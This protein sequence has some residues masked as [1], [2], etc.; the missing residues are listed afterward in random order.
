MTKIDDFSNERERLQ[1]IMQSY[2]GRD[3][4]RFLTIDHQVYQDG[5]LPKAS[6]ELLGLTASLVLRC[7]DCIN[8]H[9]IECHKAGVQTD[10]LIEA[11]SIGL[12]V[13]GSI[14]IP[15]IRR[16]IDAWDQLHTPAT[17]QA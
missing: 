11:L 4:K 16:A 2:A 14:T 5:A 12:V 9:L 17:Q 1:A 6:K 13:G 10:E 7:D 8:Y 15:H 3:M